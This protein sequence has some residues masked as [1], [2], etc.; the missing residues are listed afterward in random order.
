MGIK[1]TSIRLKTDACL[2]AC[3]P[4]VVIIVSLCIQVKPTA[5]HETD[6]LED[7]RLHCA[8]SNTFAYAR[9]LGDNYS[10]MC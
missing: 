7:G 4:L 1:A 8:R 6:R 3:L 9:N 2:L 5:G 10:W